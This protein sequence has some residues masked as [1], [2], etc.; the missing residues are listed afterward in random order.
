MSNAAVRNPQPNGLSGFGFPEEPSA[1]MGCRDCGASNPPRATDIYCAHGRFLPLDWLSSKEQ[2]VA[3]MAVVAATYGSFELAAELMWAIPLFVLYA[4]T[5]ALLAGLPLRNFVVTAR[6]VWLIMFAA[7][8][9]ALVVRYSSVR[10]QALVAGVATMAGVVVL[11]AYALAWSAITVFPSS[12]APQFRFATRIVSLALV[13]AAWSA[14]GGFA[15]RYEDLVLVA[16]AP[17]SVSVLLIL[18][19]GWLAIGAVALTASSIVMGAL[20]VDRRVPGI[21]PPD[22]PGW[23][24]LNMQQ[25]PLSGPPARNPL[26]LAIEVF[27]RALA[28]AAFIVRQVLQVA[29]VIVANILTLISYLVLY[30]AVTIINI[31]VRF[32]VV[33]ARWVYATIWTMIRITFHAVRIALLQCLKPVVSILTPVAALA[34][35]PWLTIALANETL[36]YILHGSTAALLNLLVLALSTIALLTGAGIILANQHPRI[37][38]ESFFESSLVSGAYGLVVV[39]MGG[40]LLGL[41]GTLGFGPIHVGKVTLTLTAVA[42]VL[43]IPGLT[44]RRRAAPTPQ[45]TPAP[46]NA[47]RDGKAW[48]ITVAIAMVTGS[49]AMISFF[50]LI[51]PIQ[52]ASPTGL[53]VGRHT[54]TSA[55]LHWSKLTPGRRPIRYIVMRNGREVGSVPGTSTTYEATGLAPQT[56]YTYRLIAVRGQRRSPSSAAVTV[57]T[58]TP[59]PWSATVTGMWSVQNSITSWQGVSSAPNPTTGIWTFTPRCMASECAID[60]SGTIDSSP[61][62]VTV[63]RT[64]PDYLSAPTDVSYFTCNGSPSAGTLSLK[65][66]PQRGAADSNVDWVAASWSGTMTLYA[67]PDRCTAAQVTA[68]IRGVG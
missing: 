49:I 47:R 21:K 34:A 33:T 39:L 44:R 23:H 5:G 15:L 2:I 25:M 19:I 16:G 63:A 7:Y 41:P 18:A 27:V 30:A 56:V 66:S 45:P 12:F 20:G 35:A 51:R 64:G 50:H 53:T 46:A 6:V 9:V 32:T 4:T 54:L 62:S 52:V 28:L 40:W 24:S 1:S 17:L 22:R 58:L 36:R 11:G 37:S 31:L 14:A 57:S 68:T 67:P 59:P 10:D 55:T 61:F 38:F 43:A 65:I 8:G 3:V 29:G 48:T 13:T 60:V 26:D 42:A